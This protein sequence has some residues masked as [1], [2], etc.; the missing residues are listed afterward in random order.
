MKSNPHLSL[1][2]LHHVQALLHLYDLRQ[3]ES[4]VKRRRKVQSTLLY[5]SFRNAQ[6][7]IINLTVDNLLEQLDI[8]Y[9]IIY[10]VLKQQYVLMQQSYG[11]FGCKINDNN[12]IML[13]ILLI[14]IKPIIANFALSIFI[15][16]QQ[17]TL[18][19]HTTVIPNKP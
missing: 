12:A 11:I 16:Q 18:L 15:V 19:S 7:V 1:L 5:F 4:T 13:I 9:I 10:Y 14:S 6:V 8:Y 2:H 3:Q 17:N